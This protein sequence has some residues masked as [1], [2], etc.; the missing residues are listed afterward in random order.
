MYKGNGKSA[1]ATNDSEKH[2]SDNVAACYGS[3]C[4]FTLAI[5]FGETNTVYAVPGG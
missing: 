3:S 4:K 2:I 5:N 1:V